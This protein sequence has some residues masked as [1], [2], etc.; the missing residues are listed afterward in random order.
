MPRTSAAT[1]ARLVEAAV[2]EFA[3]LGL[4]GARV[5]RI[6]AVAAAN[7][8]AI[9]D[10]FGNKEG[11]FDA[12]LI[13][14]ISDLNEANPLRPDDLPGY[15]ANLFDYLLDHPEAVRMIAWRRLERPQAGPGLSG[16]FVNHMMEL[17]DSSPHPSIG[18]VDLAILVI[19]LAN[20]WHLSSSDLLSAAGQDPTD[21][22]RISLHRRAVIA[23][24]LRLS[25]APDSGEREQT[26]LPS[27][28]PP[29]G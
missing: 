20:A 19:G 21:P 5:D 25:G 15:A 16:T 2:V 14:V 1:R 26:G 10:Y 9:Y 3:A 23:A 29:V 12:A 18:P 17:R 28:R 8:R 13:R 22:D 4:A 24:A 7:K 6:A 27:R 11:L